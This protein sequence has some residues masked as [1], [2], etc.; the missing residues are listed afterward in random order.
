LITTDIAPTS[1]VTVYMEHLTFRTYQQPQ[2]SV[3]DMAMAGNA[4]F[5]QVVIDTATPLQ[6]ILQPPAGYFGLRTPRVNT[7]MAMDTFDNCYVLGYGTGVIFAE[8]FRST[9]FSVMRCGVGMQSD[10]NYHPAMHVTALIWH[11]PIGIKCTNRMALDFVLDIEAETNAGRW[12]QCVYD[13]DDASN[14]ATGWIKYHKSAGG[15]S[16]DPGGITPIIVNGAAN[17]TL[18]SLNATADTFKSAATF[19]DLTATGTTRIN[20]GSVIQPLSVGT[21]SSA[22]TT[23][24]MVRVPN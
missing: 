1:N 6:D 3:V 9:W 12:D 23:H 11:C 14:R 2:F 5:R 7:G 8:Q 10:F 21:A 18:I 22:D 20:D 19:K 16:G 15:L 17:V 24:R 13:I 4:L